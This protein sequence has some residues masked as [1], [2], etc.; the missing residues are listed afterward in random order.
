MPDFRLDNRVALVTGGGRGIGAAIAR[1]LAEAGAHVV[2]SA[3]DAAQLE[4][5]ATEIRAAGGSADAQ[6]WDLSGEGARG[7][8][9]AT[10]VRYGRLDILV[11]AAGNQIRASA[12]EFRLADWDAVIDL[13]LRA[14]FLLA[15][16]AAARMAAGGGGSILFI[17][18][19]T[20]E[21]LGNPNTVAY[22]AAKAGV[23]GL[24]RTFA[25]ELAPFGIRVNTLAPGFIGTEMTRDIDE[26]PARK[27]LT[28][29]TPQG[30]LGEPSDVAGA[31]VF[32]ASDAAG[33][34]TG[35]TVTVDGGWSAA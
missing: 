31:A 33:Y 8:V 13:H 9:E 15:Q 1:G 30:R 21:H 34:L 6:P 23:Q 28:G 17:G 26:L 12:L 22:A 14:A 25:V 20:S 10:V 27:A 18:S 11:H 29:R 4:A 3:R 7:L 24:M 35:Q 5:V 19:L 2:T 16:S 32:L